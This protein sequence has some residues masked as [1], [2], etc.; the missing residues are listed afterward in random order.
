MTSK[1]SRDGFL[2]FSRHSP[3]SSITRSTFIKF[4][5]FLLMI[6]WLGQ[7]LY[8]WTT[9]TTTTSPSSDSFSLQTME[10]RIYQQ[11]IQQIDTVQSRYAT[12]MDQDTT[13]TTTTPTGSTTVTTGT[14]SGTFGVVPV[15]AILLAWRRID[16]LRL[17]VR[18]LQ[19]FPYIQEILVW[20]NHPRIHVHLKV[21]FRAGVG[22]VLIFPGSRCLPQSSH[23]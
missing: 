10:P 5:V 8:S 16:S 20:N 4:L 13:G 14:A 2:P 18:H 19:R 9:T 7:R 17:V 23:L 6:L 12:A 22:A 3:T 11:W 1:S 21:P 15:T